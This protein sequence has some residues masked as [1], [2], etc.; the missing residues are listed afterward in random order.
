MNTARAQQIIAWHNEDVSLEAIAEYCAIMDLSD[1]KPAHTPCITTGTLADLGRA[2]LKT[3]REHIRI[4]HPTQGAPH[5][6]HQ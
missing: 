1:L 5:A 6:L 4:I 3:A 2:Q